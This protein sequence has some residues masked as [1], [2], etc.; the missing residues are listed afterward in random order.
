[1]WP[2]PRAE[3]AVPVV[4]EDDQHLPAEL[5]C[6]AVWPLSDVNVTSTLRVPLQPLETKRPCVPLPSFLM[7]DVTLVTE[8]SRPAPGC[9]S[10]GGTV[11][12]RLPP[13]LS[14]VN[15]AS[16][17]WPMFETQVGSL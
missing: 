1:M 4:L 15:F 2:A 8:A 17:A 3:T 14:V 7:F 5:C 6:L 12:V 16:I 9:S 10:T 11:N 13:L